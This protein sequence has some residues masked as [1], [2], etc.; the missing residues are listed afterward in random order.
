MSGYQNPHLNLWRLTACIQERQ[1]PQPVKLPLSKLLVIGKGFK[2]NAPTP[3]LHLLSKRRDAAQHPL[4]DCV[5]GLEWQDA[6][7]KDLKDLNA[8]ISLFETGCKLVCRRL[9]K[10]LTKLR[11]T[12]VRMS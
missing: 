5:I 10:A 11:R 2:T 12:G 4:H 1:V 3:R 6:C 8:S 9:A 7:L